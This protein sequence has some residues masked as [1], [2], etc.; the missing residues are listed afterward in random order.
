VFLKLPKTLT[1]FAGLACALLVQPFSAQSQ[2]RSD[3]ASE[4][5]Q[6]LP[7]SSYGTLVERTD[8]GHL[9]GNPEADVKLIEF[10]SYTC[11]HCANFARQGE[12][13]IKLVYVPTGKV[14]FEIRHLL[15]DPV[16]LTAAMMAQCGDPAKF[17][18]NHAE[19]M[20][21]QSEWIEKASNATQAQMARWQFGMPSARRRAIASD[22]GFYD[23]MDRRG[24][25]R[26]ELDRCLNDDAKAESMANQSVAD[27]QTYNLR[28]T[29]SFVLNGELLSQTHSWAALQPLLDAFFK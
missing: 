21:R 28:G 16:D 3:D 29:P 23:L 27:I 18:R 13:A 7:K 17:P 12:G 25:D 11:G 9:I 5:A 1:A 4:D 20:Y 8:G 14:S 15:R 19:F 10:A 24:Y 22:L 26:V 6:N 2:T